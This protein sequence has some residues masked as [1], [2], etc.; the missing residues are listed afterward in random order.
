MFDHEST[1]LS[2]NEISTRG[3]LFGIFSLFCWFFLFG[4]VV[5]I[6]NMVMVLNT[7]FHYTW[8]VGP[9]DHIQYALQK[10]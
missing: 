7:Q 8:K 1:A 3:L 5:N 9:F 10:N 6:N 4:I 2:H